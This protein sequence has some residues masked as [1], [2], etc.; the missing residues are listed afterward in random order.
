M[1]T[2]AARRS[3]LPSDRAAREESRAAVDNQK[4][5]RIDVIVV[6]SYLHQRFDLREDDLNHHSTWTHQFL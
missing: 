6:A 2:R 1:P 4:D 3:A 5:D